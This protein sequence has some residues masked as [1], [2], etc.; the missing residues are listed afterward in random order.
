MAAAAHAVTKRAGFNRHAV[1]AERVGGAAK[2]YLLH[3]LSRVA[4]VP[5]F[6]SASRGQEAATRRR[7]MAL[8]MSYLVAIPVTDF[9]TH[10]FP[11]APWLRFVVMLRINPLQAD[12]EPIAGYLKKLSHRGAWQKRY[13]AVR[14]QGL[15][16]L[17]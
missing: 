10:Y 14:K 3:K 13:F 16:R 17:R 5:A 8:I 12:S 2:V 9:K 7:A 1:T 6:P 15:L 11:T 4:V